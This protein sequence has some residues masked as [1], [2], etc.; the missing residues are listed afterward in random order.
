MKRL[1]LLCA[2]TALAGNCAHAQKS[3]VVEPAPLGASK[4][5]KIVDRLGERYAE[6]QTFS[7]DFE[8]IVRS[9]TR[10]QVVRG[11][12]RFMKPNFARLTFDRIA[13]PAYPNLVGSDGKLAY[14][15]T[16]RGYNKDVKPAPFPGY[17][18]LAAA[19][20]ASGLEPGGEIRSAKVSRDG[21]ELRLWDSILLQAFFDI[22]SAL[23]YFYSGRKSF[24]TVEGSRTLDG[25]RYTVLYNHLSGGAVAGGTMS[26]FEQRLFIGPDGLLHL[27]TLQFKEAGAAGLQMMRLSNIKLNEPMTAESFAFSPPAPQ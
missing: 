19:R 18:P 8:Y 2:V 25:V 4:P 17:D 24:I 15:F 9:A 7:A 20:Q 21:R 26:D 6:L 10:A 11:H 3:L 23:E 1:L 27:Y 13:E 12:A 22:P 5:E 16:P 14:T